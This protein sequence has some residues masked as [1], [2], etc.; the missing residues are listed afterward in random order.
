MRIAISGASGFVGGHLT[1]QLRALG[2][3]AMGL[4]R[5][6]AL[7]EGCEVLI[8][9]AWDLRNPEGNVTRSRQLIDAAKAAGGPR[10]LF[11]SSLSAF[12]GCRSRYGAMKLAVEEVVR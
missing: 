7:A 11:I 2:H 9:A 10:I 5:S 4:P 12:D 1:E 3:E 6:G 8:H